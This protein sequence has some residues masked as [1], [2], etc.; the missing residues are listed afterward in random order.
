MGRMKDA[1]YQ[2]TYYQEHK[3]ERTEKLRDKWHNDPV[4][5]QRE[6][7]RAK[8]RRALIR[9][10]KADGRF[11]Q[12]IVERRQEM[13]PTRPPR[14]IVIGGK[15]KGDRIVGGEIVQ[16]WTTG[17]A[18]REVGRTARAIRSWLTHPKHAKRA[19][20]GA[21]CFTKD[22]AAWFTWAFAEAV[23]C[24]CER[25]YYLNGRGDRKVLR[26][27]VIEELAEAGITYV[28]TGGAEADRVAAVA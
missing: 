21:S 5:Q 15:L 13:T 16:V 19:L 18:G 10:E 2:A 25:L 1:E 6:R 3:T 12:M 4:W 26:R 27:L 9:A 8:K 20:P 17:S 22:G 24:A 14:F 7:E 11:D 28:P 23:R